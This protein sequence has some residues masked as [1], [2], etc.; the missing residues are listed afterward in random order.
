LSCNFA[1]QLP[2]LSITSAIGFG[3][4]SAE[5]Q[6]ELQELQKRMAVELKPLVLESSLTMQKILE[7]DGHTARCKLLKYFV[8]AERDRLSTKKSL[9]GLFL[10]DENSE[11]SME[12]SSA[13]PP[14]EMITDDKKVEKKSQ[15]F[16]DEPDA[17]Q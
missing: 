17:F 14:E 8:T 13:I 4:L 3:D 7:A 1:K 11:S 12:V 9:K 16:Y 10:S 6:Q 5:L 2:Q 15:M